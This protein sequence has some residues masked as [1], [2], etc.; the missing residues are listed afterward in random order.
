MV[1]H[2]EHV[3]EVAGIDH[4][5]IGGDYD[6]TDTYPVGLEDVS[7]Y[8]RLVAALVER[9]WSDGDL[10]QLVRGNTLRVMRDAEAVS[11]DL[12]ATRDP[13]LRTIEELDG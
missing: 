1:R 5:G 11:R 9:G 12:Q 7:G 6:G 13:S 10:A 2:L 8:P 3:R 4:V